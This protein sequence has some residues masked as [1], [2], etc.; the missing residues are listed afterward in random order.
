MKDS[1]RV[2][3]VGGGVGGLTLAQ[4]LHTAGV[5]VVVYEQDPTPQ[6]RNQGYRIHIDPDGNAALGECLDPQVFDVLRRSSSINGDLVTTFTSG[7]ELVSALEFPGIPEKMITAVDRNAFRRGLLTGL[8][9]VVRFGRTVS[10]YRITESGRVRIE[11]AEGGGDEGDLLV[12]ADGVG[13][14]IRRRLLPN[15]VVEDFGLRC[16]YGRMTLTGRLDPDEFN[17]GLCWVT[18]GST[19]GAGFGPV[20]FRTPED[21]RPDY[22]MVTLCAT[23]SRLGVTDD[24]L[25]GMSAQELWKLSTDVVSDW[26]PAIRDIYAHSDI[27]SFFPITFRISAPVDNWGPGP[28]TLLGDAIHTMPPTA[29]AG[30]N[31]ALADAASLAREIL[32]ATRGEKS[33]TAAVADYQTVMLPRGRAAIDNS[34]RMAAQMFVD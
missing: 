10:D 34:R 32:S 25:F 5:D 15:A 13:S 14:V 26:H 33:L 4:A 7:L 8:D 18:E 12:G 23:P 28:V 24:E 6:T 20:V 3:I 17:R 2:L 31:T 16:I 21:G 9:E 29:G 1:T 11:F 30:A 22:L 19:C 27:D